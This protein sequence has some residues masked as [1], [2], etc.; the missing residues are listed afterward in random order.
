MKIYIAGK[1]VG[2]DNYLEKFKNVQEKLEGEGHLIMNPTILP[3]GFEWDEYM[4]ICYSMIDV[5]DAVYLL[6]NWKNSKGATLERE[7][8]I[9]KNKLIKYQKN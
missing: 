2:E 1:I 9:N 7:Y 5:C 3:K 6:N 4:K 8:A